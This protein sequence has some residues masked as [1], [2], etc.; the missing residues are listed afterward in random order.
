M[1]WAKRLA[2]VQ[3]NTAPQMASRSMRSRAMADQAPFSVFISPP[4]ARA[5]GTGG[6]VQA[7]LNPTNAS[8]VSSSGATHT[9]F[10][11]RDMRMPGVAVPVKMAK[12]VH[13][14]SCPL[15]AANRSCGK[16]SAKNSVFRRA[17]ERAVDAH[18]GK[19]D[20]RQNASG[21]VEPERECR[22]AHQQHFD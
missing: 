21:R 10:P 6:I 1:F 3:K 7:A 2:I 11:V 12:N 18:S 16:S 19:D 5:G 4:S 9:A 15:P 14:S 20:Q 17:E 22:R 8:V 13:I